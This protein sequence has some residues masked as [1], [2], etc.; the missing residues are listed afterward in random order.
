MSVCIALRDPKQDQRVI[1]AFK[2]TSSARS[3]PT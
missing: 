3:L 2:K 1:E